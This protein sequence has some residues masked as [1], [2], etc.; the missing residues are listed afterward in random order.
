MK[1]IINECLDARYNLALEEYVLKNVKEDIIILWQ[2]DNF[3][4]IG[5]N[6]DTVSEINTDYVKV[7]KVNVVRRIT[8]GG[9]VY[10]DMGNVNFSYITNIDDNET[11][12]VD[13]F[14]T[15]TTPL[16]EFLQ[17]CGISAEF[18]GRNDLVVSGMKFSGNAQARHKN[19]LLHHGT[20]LFNSDLTKL[21]KILKPKTDKIKSKGVESVESR[22]TN[23][24]PYFKEG[25]VLTINKFKHDLLRKFLQIENI[26]T[27]ITPFIYN[28]SKNDKQKIDDLFK[29]K[30]SSYS[31]NYGEVQEP[32][33]NF[34]RYCRYEGVG[35]ITFQLK[36]IDG[37]IIMV[38]IIGDFLGYKDIVNI[39]KALKNTTF[40][41]IEVKAKL[42]RFNL[43]N[44]I[45]NITLDNVLDCLFDNK[46]NNTKGYGVFTQSLKIITAVNK[47]N[48]SNL[49]DS[50]GTYSELLSLETFEIL[51]T[52]DIDGLKYWIRRNGNEASIGISN[53]IFD[54]IDNII[55]IRITP[56][57]YN[58]T[59]SNVVGSIESTKYTIDIQ[60][61]ISGRLND[62]NLS[63]V[64]TNLDESRLTR[65]TVED[66]NNWIFKIR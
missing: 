5:K 52:I 57:P 13:T 42:K 12:T 32:E 11:I 9:A 27:P 46:K 26:T 3:V 40:K 34:T 6:Q 7:N 58:V 60:T 33:F 21:G 2:S 20:I 47:K 16:I 17:S 8:G 56:P 61:P 43:N 35:G 66:E 37:K 51:E 24:L 18:R 65:A 41:R 23:L 29:N 62:I 48:K 64:N 25:Q 44:Y 55:Y 50:Y 63:I 36:I 14:R 53:S 31:W 4:I 59:D 28:L 30:Y 15:F 54:T 38:K 22:V 49:I 1:T 45:R 19:R 39:E 10:H